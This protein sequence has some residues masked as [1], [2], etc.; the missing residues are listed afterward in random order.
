MSEQLLKLKDIPVFVTR[1]THIFP[2]F[3]QTVE[4]GREMSINAINKSVEDFGAHIVI[5]CQKVTLEDNPTVDEIYNVGVLAKLKKISTKSSKSLQYKF[6]AINRLKLTD[7][8]VKDEKYFS[9]DIEIL[10]SFVTSKADFSLKMSRSIKELLKLQDLLPDE[11][12]DSLASSTS[13]E[14]I[15]DTFAQ[16]LPFIPVSERQKMLEELNIEKRLKLIFNCLS[17]KQQKNDIEAEISEK[18]K[19]RVDEQQR[20][21]ILREK[22]KTIKEQLG[23]FDG[24]TDE[25]RRFNEKLKEKDMPKKVKERIE[26]EI[27]RYELMPQASSEANV[28]RSY[29][30]CLLSL[31]WTEKTEEINDLVFAKETLDTDHFGLEKVKERI[32]EYLAVKQMTNSIKGQIICL[33]GPP[34]VG[35]S[36]LVKSI[37]TATGRTLVKWKLNGVKDESEVR[38]HRKT[39]IGAM[40]GKI[41]QHM[42]DAGS[43][44][45]V[46][47]IDE[48]DKMGND[49]RGDPASAM[50]EVLDP[51]H[52]DSFT[53]NYVEE[54]YDLSEVMF[55]AT[56]NYLENIPEALLDRMEV[57]QLSSYTE[58][59]KF[60]IA[61]DHMISKIL[62]EHGLKPEQLQFTDEAIYEII[63][64]YTREAGVRNLRKKLQAISRKFIVKLLKKEITTLKVT[65][66]EVQN[67]LGKRDFEHTEKEK[68]SQIGVVTGLAYTQFGGDILPIE[69]NTFQGKGNLVLTGKLGE[70]MKE[71]ATIALNYVKANAL[72]Y[73]V[74][75]AFFEKH[76]IHIHV[77]EGAVPKDGPSA[78][79]TITTAIISALSKRAVSRDIGMT[80][81]ITLRGLVLPIGGLKE[82]SISANRSGI[83]TILIP[84]KNLKDLDDIPQEVQDNLK[85]IP[86]SSYEDVFAHIFE[87]SKVTNANI[88]SI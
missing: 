55:I 48:I 64:Y 46:F 42:K 23:E 87:N 3:S 79:I 14:E 80:G 66:Q 28:I 60:K 88:N 54:S 25:I 47:L 61:K 8:Q 63:K 27:S 31:P 35:K 73:G 19:E 76:D 20:E 26:T 68:E 17:E 71:S 13:E 36:S 84:S 70:V 77:P 41:I 85:I 11:V 10:D 82:K 83:Q 30:E 22:L 5:V 52:N 37:A 15:V 7:L 4:V 16:R 57:I 72:K 21:Y 43:I 40:P 62:I 58:Q 1:D 74:D 24:S 51:D 59:E 56:A 65:P 12:I 18:I 45:P 53:D 6:N 50:L 78:G 39:Y 81:E 49:Y 29:I 34:G 44:N 69:V 32:I 67:Y 9:A 38:G 75:E 33:V 2:G 86:V